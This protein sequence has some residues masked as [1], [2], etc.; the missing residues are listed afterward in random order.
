M[1]ISIIQKESA[2]LERI[3]HDLLDLAQLEGES[4][5]IKKEPIAMAQLIHD[6]VES[7]E[8]AM[9]QAQLNIHLYLDEEVIIFAD[10]DRMEQ[11]LR[12]LLDRIWSVKFNSVVVP[13]STPIRAP[14]KSSKV[15]IPELAG[16]II[17]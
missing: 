14:F 9:K 8:L 13:D 3:V 16:T 2:R 15:V 12:N 11:V 5:P 6:V 1:I 4:Y 7:F 10:Y 17:P